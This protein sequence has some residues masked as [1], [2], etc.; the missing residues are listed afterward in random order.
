MKDKKRTFLAILVT[1]VVL[2]M[3]FCGGIMFTKGKF[4]LEL[5]GKILQ[6]SNTVE[7]KI[8]QQTTPFAVAVDNFSKWEWAMELA[9]DEDET[10]FEI[11]PLPTP[12]QEIL[13]AI[14][15]PENIDDHD[16]VIQ[17]FQYGIYTDKNYINLKNGGQV[18][19]CTSVSNDELSQLSQQLPDFN[20]EL[21]SP[22]PQVLI[23]HTHTTESFEPYTRDFYDKDFT[24][25]TTDITMNM[26][27]VGNEI[28]AQLESA[29][30]TTLHDTT[31][32]DY[33]S[34]NG[35]YQSSRETVQEILE[36]YPS[37]KVVLDVHR[38]GIERED[39]TRIAPVVEIDGKRC[40]QIMIISCCDNDGN[41]PNFRENFKL[42]CL[43]Q[44]QLETDYE[45][46]TRPILFD[47]RFYNQDLSVGSLLIEIG[48]H[49]N[50]IDEAKY[51]GQLVGK[52]IANALKTLSD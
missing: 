21:N 19:N 11:T 5:S 37:I 31:V 14:P 42:A 27:A 52:S 6:K 23:Y 12:S 26:V 28:Q 36:K 40:A 13:D 38:D 34:Y 2:N 22:Q 30:I 29:G 48:S 8:T 4:I 18:R 51:S 25:K 46:I 49:G 33:P 24:C 1:S 44:S 16:G 47:Y 45:G 43:F 17:T 15:Y 7:Q 35:S 9:P 50:S 39:G 41:I 10:P 3:G 20:I 32:H